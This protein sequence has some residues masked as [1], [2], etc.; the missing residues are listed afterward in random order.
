MG[1]PKAIILVGGEGTRLRPLTLQTHKSMVPILNRPFMEHLLDHLKMHGVHE[2]VLA[3]CHLHSQIIDYFGDGSRFGMKMHYVV[4]ESPLGT[5]GA[6]KNAAR[7]MDD[8]CFVLNGDIYNE[9]DLTAML[10]FHRS[11]GAL[12]SI[13]L[14]HVEDVSAYGVVETTEAGR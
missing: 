9:L 2:V 6:V 7:H 13:A 1:T 4:E 11:R 12:A 14:T 3:L 10:D 8:T 5:A